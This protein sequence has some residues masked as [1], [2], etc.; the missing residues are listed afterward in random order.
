[1]HKE[2]I[3]NIISDYQWKKREVERLKSTLKRGGVSLNESFVAPYGIEATMPKGSSI[4]SMAELEDM[5]EREKKLYIRMQR[6]QDQI[7]FVE[8]IEDY[9]EDDKQ[10]AIY[11]CMLH[12]LSFRA[13]SKHLGISREKVRQLKDETL[14]HISQNCHLSQTWQYLLDRKITC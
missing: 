2:E 6:Y 14:N 8:M 7:D 11:N 1:M 13:I 3:E 5:D 9:I 10:Q 4:R 12:G